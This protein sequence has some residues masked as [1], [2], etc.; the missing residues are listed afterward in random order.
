MAVVLPDALPP[1]DIPAALRR[2]NGKPSL[3]R[4][5][6]LSFAETNAA[7]CDE[8]ATLLDQGRTQDAHRLAHTLKG[9]AGAL[10]LARVAELAGALELAL[11]EDRR[12]RA[13]A[14]LAQ[15]APHIDHAVAAAGGLLAA[16]SPVSVMAPD[17][18]RTPDAPESDLQEC[19]RILRDLVRRRSLSARQ[20]F[21]RLADALQL[22]DAARQAHPLYQALQRLDYAGAAAMIDRDFSGDT[23]RASA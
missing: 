18:F 23:E 6:I 11:D 1:F 2:M 14:V 8:I 5:L 16:P 10:E 17:P 20:S 4:R 9:V 15:L 7:F 21:A 13:N 12:D 19:V 3:L 22:D